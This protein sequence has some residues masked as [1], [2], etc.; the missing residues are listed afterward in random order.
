VWK[1]RWFWNLAIVYILGSVWPSH[2]LDFAIL[3]VLVSGRYP[4]LV[5]L[6][7]TNILVEKEVLQCPLVNPTE[8]RKLL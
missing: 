1:D 4:A 6:G 8:F 2:D 5:K 7:Q 3:P